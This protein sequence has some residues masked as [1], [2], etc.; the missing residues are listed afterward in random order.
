MYYIPQNEKKQYD[1]VTYPRQFVT[2][3]WY[4][5][6]L[7]LILTLIFALA[8][9]ILLAFGGAALGGIEL[10]MDAQEYTKLLKGGYDSM[11]LTTLTGAV[12]TLGQVVVLLPA[13]M[14]ARAIVRDRTWSSYSSSRGGWDM[15][16]FIK[17]LVIAILVVSA[18]IYARRVWLHGFQKP[19]GFSG[20]VVAVVVVLGVLQCITEQYAFRGLFMQTL[21][22]WFRVP[23][24]AIVL[25]AVPFMLLHPY[26]NIG[27][28]L[29]FLT[30]LAF[31]I[32]AWAGRGI[33]VSSALHIGNNLIIF[34]MESLGM[35][36]LGSEVTMQDF[37]FFAVIYVVYTIIIVILSK[38]T[39]WFEKVRKNDAEIFNSKIN[40][41]K[42]ARAQK[43]ARRGK[44]SESGSGGGN[45][46][47]GSGSYQG[48]H[49]KH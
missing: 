13:M 12:F 25:T 8:L 1:Y 33:E 39:H 35:H 47:S 4:K 22:S 45:S 32:S 14:L 40:A 29:V 15:G 3:S 30:G 17:C 7:T 36:E 11:D 23:I 44:S 26:N 16:L 38:T 27:K 41:K 5:P 49:F 9:I 18:P 6:L 43:R 10:G 37:I 28:G 24:I 46:I 19:A 20:T 2:Y 21:G 42:A 48:K 34:V 31:G